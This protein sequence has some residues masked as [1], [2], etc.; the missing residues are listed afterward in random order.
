[1]SITVV[2]TPAVPG[3][4]PG[5]AARRLASLLR[6]PLAGYLSLAADYGDTIRMP[7]APRQYLFLLSKSARYYCD[8]TQIQE[9]AVTGDNGSNFDTGKTADRQLG[10]VEHDLVG[11]LVDDGVDPNGAREGGG[12][13]GGL[14]FDVVGLRL[15]RPWQTERPRAGRDGRRGS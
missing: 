5:Q 3:P 11:C 9:P 14:Q 2:R 10:R 8:M 13:D 7:I 1:M 6:D 12:G 4:G 15:D